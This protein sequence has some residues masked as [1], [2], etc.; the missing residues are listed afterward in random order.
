MDKLIYTAMTGASHVLQRQATV[1]QNLSNSNT[2]GF[3]SMVNAFRAVPLVGEGLPTRTFVVDTTTGYD[4][5]PAAMEETGRPL[6]IAVNGKGWITVQMPDGTEAYTRDG[7]LQISP[8]GILQT[9]SG[10]P[11]ASDSGQIAIPPDSEITIGADGTVSTVPTGNAPSQGVTVGRIKLVNP[12]E[13][14]LVRG[15]DGLF[16]VKGG[17]ASTVQYSDVTVVPGH[18]EGSNVHVVETMVDMISLARQFDMQMKV[19]KTASD[20]AQQA[21]QIL[22]VTG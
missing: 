21:S 3:R 13:K 9:R 1:S 14:S 19:L 17:A 18:L 15:D 16:R 10:L 6:D 7:S 22:N 20:D 2:P 8:Q 11:V 12:P 4:F 5:T